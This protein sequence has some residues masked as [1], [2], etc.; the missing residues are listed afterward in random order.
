MLNRT[1]LLAGMLTLACRTIS[2]TLDLTPTTNE[3]TSQ[4]F[5]YVQLSFKNDG[6]RVGYNP[7]LNWTYRGSP[8][9]LKLTPPNK[10]FAEAVIEV[11]A[12]G[13]PFTLELQQSLAKEAAA[14]VPPGSQAVEILKQDEN[15]ILIDGRRTFEVVLS[16][17]ALGEIFQRSIVFVQVEDMRLSFRLTARAAD[18]SAL[19]TMFHASIGSWH[20]RGPS[21]YPATTAAGLSP[22]TRRD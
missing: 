15:T 19:K 12:G 21:T 10:S 5:T 2:A 6:G 18:F 13:Q 16:Y 11:M 3:Y 9:R 17:K 4:G 7:P 8:A 1:L 20:W 22:N 14:E